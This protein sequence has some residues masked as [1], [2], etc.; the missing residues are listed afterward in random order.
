VDY[1]GRGDLLGRP[2]IGSSCETNAFNL[3]SGAPV[4]IRCSFRIGLSAS[5][6]AVGESTNER[7]N[8]DLVDAGTLKKIETVT[9]K[10]FPICLLQV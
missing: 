4:G 9:T 2:E 1:L 5:S 8:I 6:V 10:Q 7:Q 3:L